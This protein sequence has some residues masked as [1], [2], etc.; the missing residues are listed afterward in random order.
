MTIYFYRTKLKLMADVE[1]LLPEVRLANNL[2]NGRDTQ[3]NR[4][5]TLRLLRTLPPDEVQRLI[6]GLELSWRRHGEVE[7]K[8]LDSYR[9]THPTLLGR[10]YDLLRKGYIPIV[11]GFE[12]TIGGFAKNIQEH[13]PHLHLPGHASH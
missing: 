2:H 3:Q 6:G 7:D 13:A 5:E 4:I 10:S 12:K 9:M 11:R 1:R 8:H